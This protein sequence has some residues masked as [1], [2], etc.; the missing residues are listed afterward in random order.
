MIAGLSLLGT[1]N[2]SAADCEALARRAPT[3]DSGAVASGWS[4]L[5]RC[6]AAMAE[7]RFDDFMR[8]TKDVDALVA[9]AFAAMDVK[10]YRAVSALLEKITDYS[11]RESTAKAVGDQCQGHAVADFLAA[12][13]GTAKDRAFTS[14]R[15]TMIRC[16]DPAV[17]AWLQT[18]VEAP[19]SAAIHDKYAAVVE[20]WRRQKKLDALPALEKAAIKAGTAGGPFGTLADAMAEAVRPEGFSSELPPENKKSLEESMVRVARAVDPAHARE[21]AERLF[22]SGAESTAASLLPVVWPDRVQPDGSMLYGVA[23]LESCDATV[24]V[25]YAGIHEA[26][27]HWSISGK[28]D[29]AARAFKPKLKCDS[30]VWVVVTSPEPLADSTAVAA[31]AQ[32]LATKWGAEQ[33]SEASI[34]AEK[35][36]ILP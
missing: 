16:A 17:L 3:L 18:T 7:A 26:A 5:A 1:L 23:A 34:R 14:W 29:E 27:T 28:M 13:Y 20:A 33:K 35:D 19:P 36:L 32:E 8:S 21:V 4:D 9:L 22:Q 31:F 15:E 24:V 10:Q 2:A 12:N 6:D 30:G 11:A 25:H